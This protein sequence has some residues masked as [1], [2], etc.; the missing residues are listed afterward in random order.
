MNTY[1]DS[2]TYGDSTA[3]KLQKFIKEYNNTLTEYQQINQSYLSSLS[4]KQGQK[5]QFK[6]IPNSAFWGEGGLPLRNH[7]AT[8][9]EQC[10]NLCIA[11]S[12]CSGAT[13]DRSN[14][15]C[16]I[17]TGKGSMV[18]STSGQTAIVSENV[19]YLNVLQTLNQ[20]M[21]DINNQIIQL[22]EEIGTHVKDENKI[23][24]QTLQNNYKQLLEDRQKIKEMISNQKKIAG[25]V[26]DTEL[27]VTHSYTLYFFFLVLL[28]VCIY[29]F[30]QWI[31][32]PNINANANANTSNLKE[33]SSMIG[34]KNQVTKLVK[35]FFSSFFRN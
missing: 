3:L 15:Y 18:P 17:R 11:N 28:V 1:D 32:F 24:S 19:Y 26:N 13:F 4:Q 7:T 31:V 33:G 23:S 25:E 9:V 21:Q 10:K 8:N 29:L 35:R 22:S 16:W 34:G 6:S 14:N 20:K 30:F 12:S 27:S 2:K 5:K